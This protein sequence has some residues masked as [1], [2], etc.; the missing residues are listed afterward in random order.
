MKL[1]RRTWL[2]AALGATLAPRPLS[3]R[4]QRIV[5][6]GGAMT[7][8]VYALG[9]GDQVVAVDTTSLYPRAALSLPKIGYLRQLAVEGVLS[10][11]PD[12]VLADRDAGPPNVLQQLRATG[13]ILHQYE[14][15]LSAE[16]VPDKVR[17][18]GLVLDRATKG[19]EVATAISTDLATLAQAV[20][21]VEKRPRV[22]FI[23]GTIKGR[24][25]GRGHHRRSCHQPC[26]RPE[27]CR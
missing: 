5:C 9:A 18:V 26:R 2:L 20:A 10:L 21:R 19:E 27:C 1:D 24:M 14:G 4:Q 6:A 23:L 15:P 13:S 17:F 8:C 25:A 22:L 11:S 12:I 7:E 3:A 16:A